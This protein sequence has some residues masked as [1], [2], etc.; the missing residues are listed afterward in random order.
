[1]QGERDTR[2]ATGSPLPRSPA[3]GFPI[4]QVLGLPPNGVGGEDKKRTFIEGEGGAP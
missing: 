4:L 2:T 3:R 1:M